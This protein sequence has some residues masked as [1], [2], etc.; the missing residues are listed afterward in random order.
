ML[1]KLD[2]K[3]L[4]ADDDASYNDNVSMVVSRSKEFI[5]EATCSV[6]EVFKSYFL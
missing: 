5:G 4:E 2:M 3:G 1:L 6:Q